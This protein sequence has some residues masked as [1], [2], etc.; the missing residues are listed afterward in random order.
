MTDATTNQPLKVI[1][2]P[3]GGA[4]LDIPAALIPAAEELFRANAVTY[5]TDELYVSVDGEPDM[6][7]INFGRRENPADVQRLLDSLP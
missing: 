3:S 2:L 6:G 4:Y 5:W 7:V 1:P